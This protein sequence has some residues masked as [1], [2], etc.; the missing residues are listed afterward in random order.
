MRTTKEQALRLGRE[1]RGLITEAVFA[2]LIDQTITDLHLNADGKLFETRLDGESTDTGIRFSSAQATALIMQM[3]GMLGREVNE[4]HPNLEG[5]VPLELDHIIRVS[6]SI[7]PLSRDGPIISL[8]LHR[9]LVLSIAE[10]VAQGGLNAWQAKR[11]WDA[12]KARENILISG[13]TGSGKSTMA[14]TLIDLAVYDAPKDRLIIIE[15]TE[16]LKCTAENH[17]FLLTTPQVD[18]TAALRAVLRMA[19]NRIIVGEVRG[20]EALAMLKAM[21]TGHPGGI[22]TI[23]GKDC[24]GALIRLDGMIQEAGVPSQPVLIGHAIQLVVQMELQGGGQRRV[25]SMAEVKPV[26]GGYKLTEISK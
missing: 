2:R 20:P 18:M 7:L 15:D 23:H 21:T 14:N 8:R 19:P 5:K 12:V 24:E 25:T 6:A 1:L 17:V 9:I 16:E 26:K 10:W 3:S 11:L 22:T 13:G 4:E